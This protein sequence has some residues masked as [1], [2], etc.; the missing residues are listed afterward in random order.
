M[1][2]AISILLF[3]VWIVYS[4]LEGFREGVHFHNRMTASPKD[5]LEM[6]PWFAFQ[7]ALMLS[8]TGI[9]CYFLTLHILYSIFF[10]V[11][12]I[13]VFSLF[14]DGAYH[15]TR[16]D[17]NSTIYEDRWFANP[18]SKTASSAKIDFNFNARFILG[19]IGFASFIFSTIFFLIL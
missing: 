1:I 11:S 7:R 9:A 16:N 13:L 18:I 5:N 19:L 2:V 17:L 14:H 10:V 15:M 8:V 6:H 4:H 3:F 12:A